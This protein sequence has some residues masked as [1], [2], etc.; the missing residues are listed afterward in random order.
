VPRGQPE[1]A[2]PLPIGDSSPVEAASRSLTGSGLWALGQRKLE[3]MGGRSG[4]SF[5]FSG[6]F[7]ERFSQL[8][9]FWKDFK[10]WT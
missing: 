4:P 1:L 7:V 2:P 9:P 5:S 8:H 10:K 3:G 6:P